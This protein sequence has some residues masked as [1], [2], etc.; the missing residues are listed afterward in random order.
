MTADTVY[1]NGN[2]GDDILRGGAQGVNETIQG[3][4]GD[5]QIG[6]IPIILYSNGVDESDGFNYSAVKTYGYGFSM[7][8]GDVVYDGGEGDDYI[9]A[10]FGNNNSRYSKYYGGN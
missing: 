1:I 10:N 3:G 2:E 9:W 7:N 8:T 5:D 4:K 6:V